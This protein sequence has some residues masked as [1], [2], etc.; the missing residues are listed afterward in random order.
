MI[1]IVDLTQTE[2]IGKIVAFTERNQYC[3]PQ[4][5]AAGHTTRK[6]VPRARKRT[7]RKC[8]PWGRMRTT[9][10]CVPRV[11][12]HYHAREC[13]PRAMGENAYHARMGATRANAYHTCEYE[14]R[15]R[16]RTAM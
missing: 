11:T 3:D 6:Y 13:V 15:A 16:M 8:V 10:Q 14:P 1:E 12:M 7:T 9:R 5:A 2:P 4:N